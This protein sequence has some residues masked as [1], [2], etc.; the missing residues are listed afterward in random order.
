[1]DLTFRAR[2]TDKPAKNRS[3]V[4]S[5]KS[6]KLRHKGKKTYYIGKPITRLA[7][8]E[9]TGLLPEDVEALRD[10]FILDNPDYEKLAEIKE[11]YFDKKYALRKLLKRMTKTGE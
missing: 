5:K 10:M 1:M 2:L 11:R 9:D 6:I 3:V 4:W 7:E 8:Y